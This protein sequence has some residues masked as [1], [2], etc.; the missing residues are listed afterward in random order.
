MSTTFLP[1]AS[2]I[3]LIS[4]LFHSIPQVDATGT[5]VLHCITTDGNL[6]VFVES[7]RSTDNLFDEYPDTGLR[8]RNDITRE[9]MQMTPTGFFDDVDPDEGDILPGCPKHV[10]FTVSTLCNY[11]DDDWLYYGEDDDNLY[12]YA[13]WVYFDFPFECETDISYTI[14]GALDQGLQRR[15]LELYPATISVYEYCPPPCN[16]VTVQI[17]TDLYPEET[18]WKIK[19]AE[20]KVVMQKKEFESPSTLYGKTRCLPK[21]ETCHGT[22]YTFTIYDTEGNGLCCGNNDEGYYSVLVDDVEVATG[23]GTNFTYN[24]TIS[25]CGSPPSCATIR[26]RKP[27]KETDGCFW[28]SDNNG[29]GRCRKCSSIFNEKAC[30]EEEGS[31]TWVSSWDS[32]TGI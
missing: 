11:E 5:A 19:D 10:P 32:C 31:C 16:D 17:K 13:H 20:G 15:C 18:S 29:G 3:G 6:R 24:E 23:G 22:N 14:L 26:K 2:L 30:E 8:I 4:V 12:G 7:T 1:K 25:L 28:R 9:I 21:T 27:C